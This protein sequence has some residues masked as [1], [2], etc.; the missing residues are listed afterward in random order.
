MAN[1]LPDARRLPCHPATA[2]MLWLFFMV[3][4]MLAGISVL[5]VASAL[6]LTGF[7]RRTGQ[8][9]LRYVRRSRWLLL[10]LLLVHAWSIP[11]APLWPS[12]GAAGPSQAGVYSGLLQ[13]WRLVLV[14]AAL[15]V[16]MTRL[17]RE[18]LLAGIYTMLSPLRYLGQAPERIAVRIW[19]TLRYAESLMQNPQRISFRQRMQQLSALPDTPEEMMQPLLLP[20][21]RYG[22]LDYACIV[23]ATILGIWV[24]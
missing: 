6:V 7:T 22:W 2:V 4:V 1:D 16:L 12:L 19:L 8:Q 17:S 24:R 18:D 10:V 5:L 15:A 13:S 23:S 11:G 20:I 9:F 14:L 21:Y 3:W